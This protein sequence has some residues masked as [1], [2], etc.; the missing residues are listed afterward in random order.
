[1]PESERAKLL[2]SLSSTIF[3]QALL[4]EL[5]DSD[6]QSADLDEAQDMYCGVNLNRYLGSRSNVARSDAHR[7]LVFDLRDDEFKKSLRVTKP[8]F[9]SVWQLIRGDVR[10]AQRGTKPQRDVAVQ[11]AIA[12]EWF[13]A[14]GN[15]NSNWNHVRHY[16]VGA[17]TVTAYVSRVRQALLQHY[18]R[19]VKWPSDIHRAVSSAFHRERYGLPGV[20]GMVDGTHVCFDQKPHIDGALHYNRKCRYSLNVQVV[21]NEDKR[22]LM[23]YTGWPGSCA[24]FTVFAKSPVLQQTSKHF[25]ADQFLLGDSGYAVSKHVITPYKKPAALK[26]DNAAF[27]DVHCST[28]VI[29]ENT[30]GLWKNRWMSLKGIRTQVRKKKDFAVVNNHILACAMLHNIGLEVNDV[31]DDDTNSDDEDSNDNNTETE[32]EAARAGFNKR[33]RLKRG[34]LGMSN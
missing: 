30:I 18:G 33:E 5:D 2:R 17:G 27:N 13:E 21:C 32:D 29:V 3:C 24:D 26:P 4:D 23:I 20:I 14:C 16:G 7:H 11:L 10:F 19:Y 8:M 15:G 22:I 31:W 9:E 34:L 25:K 6:S 28:R 12:L 1:M